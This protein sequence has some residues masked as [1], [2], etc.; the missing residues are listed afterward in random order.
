MTDMYETA[1]ARGV[2]GGLMLHLD[3]GRRWNF[4]AVVDGEPGSRPTL[5]MRTLMGSRDITVRCREFDHYEGSTPIFTRVRWVPIA[6]V[7]EEADLQR[8]RQG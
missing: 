4:D 8:S 5:R 6:W 2:V 7:E 1:V 3:R